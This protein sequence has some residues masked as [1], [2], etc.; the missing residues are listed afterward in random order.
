MEIRLEG[1]GNE[2]AAMGSY[3]FTAVGVLHVELLA[4]HISMVSVA[5]WPRQCY[6]YT[7]MIQFKSIYTFGTSKEGAYLSFWE[8]ECL[9]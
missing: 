6:L 5:N 3:F 9:K 7:V 2:W 1:T 8:T 4:C